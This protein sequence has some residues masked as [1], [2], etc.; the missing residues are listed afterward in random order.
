MFSPKEKERD[1]HACMQMHVCMC[2]FQPQLNRQSRVLTV[3]YMCECVCCYYIATPSTVSACLP[4]HVRPCVSPLQYEFVL[5]LKGETQSHT[6]KAHTSWYSRHLCHILE[7]VGRHQRDTLIP[8]KQCTTLRG[9][10][11]CAHERRTGVVAAKGAA[12]KGHCP[13]GPFLGL[14]RQEMPG[15]LGLFRWEMLWRRV[16]AREPALC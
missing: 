15:C 3:N 5:V 9:A 2:I 11:A 7:G 6:H 12:A 13:L 8:K 16:E 14:G 1:K 10:G 4:V